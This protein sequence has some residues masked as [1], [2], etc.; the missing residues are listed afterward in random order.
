MRCLLL[1]LVCLPA[2]A[3][4]PKTLGMADILAW[5]RIQSAQV[6][7]DGNWFAYQLTPNEGNSSVMIRSLKDGKETTF[8]VGEL[9]APTGG[10]GPPVAGAA[11][12]RFSEDSKWAAMTV[13]PN[14]PK[15]KDRKPPIN[16]MVL[17]ELA[18]GKKSEFD[19]VR[20]YGFSGERGGWLAM[21]RY[22][23]EGQKWDGADLILRELATGDELNTGNVSEYAFDKRGDWLAYVVDANEMAGNG[24]QLRNMET[25]AVMPLDSAKATYK[26]VSWTEKGDALAVLRGVEDKAFED[27]PYAV[28]GFRKL[29]ATARPEKIVYDPKGVWDSRIEGE[30]KGRGGEAGNNTRFACGRASGGRERARGAGI[31]ALAGQATA[32]AAAGGRGARQDV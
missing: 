32:A 28:V 31:V 29:S 30:E 24:V 22:K 21:L 19:R 11:G 7:N 17:V 2:F 1:L 3:E 13:Y 15:V 25:G 23:P 10:F 16:K 6:S 4:A 8:P 20:R 9:P 26:G 18:T 5:K 27:K 12:V 14:K